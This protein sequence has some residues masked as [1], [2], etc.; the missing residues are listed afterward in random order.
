M[1]EGIAL[2]KRKTKAKKESNTL[3]YIAWIL[4]LIALALLAIAGGYYMGF[5][6]AKSELASKEQKKKERRLELLKKIEETNVPTVDSVNDRLKKVL[7]E[8]QK[9]KVDK[10]TTIAVKEEKKNPKLEKELKKVEE[11]QLTKISKTLHQEVLKV[12]EYAG[13]AHEYATNETKKPP[14][15]VKR[16]VKVVSSSNPRLAII[17][18][19]VSVKS[20]VKAI[21]SLGYDVTMSFLPPSP[22]R[23]NSAKLA[24]QE[25]FYMV[26]LPMEAQSFSA[27]EPDTLRVSDTQQKVSSRI[28]EIKKAFPKVRYINNHTGSKY[29]EDEKAMNRLI[30]AMNSNDIS[31]IDSRT[32]SKTQAPKV[33]KNFA[34]KYVARDVFLDHHMEKDYIKGQIKQ[35]IKIA[36]SE[37][38]AI[39]IGHPHKNTIAALRESK[40]LFK[41]ID[42]VMI[43][44]VY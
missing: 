10:K 34:L 7:Q 31:F 4:A 32:T 40:S 18:D 14:S 36:K 24:A 16:E 22:A 9:V 8:D 3:K 33:M 20:Q 38:I 6:N 11:K 15:R 44:K 35:A 1:N 2:S 25:D 37:G 17:I 39:A 43:N 12:R 42:L 13:A 5:N 27:E 19:D 23:P 41:D 21:K 28:R 26:H 29:T 30:L